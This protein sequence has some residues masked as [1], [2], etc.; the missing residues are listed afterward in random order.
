MDI[1]TKS[2]FEEFKSNFNITQKKEEDAFED[3]ANYCILS[4]H[5]KIETVTKDTIK[6]IHIGGGNDTGIDGFIFVV[7][8]KQV[9]TKQEVKDLVKANGYLDVKF[10][11]IQAKT[12]PKF[13]VSEIGTFLE[14]SKLV[15]RRL[16]ED[17]LE[18]PYNQDIGD[19]YEL[20]EF[21]YS[22]A[23]KFLNSRKPTLY[24]Y[25]VTTGSYDDANNDVNS[26]FENAKTEIQSYGLLESIQWF[27]VDANHL[28][29][30]YA[31]TKQHEEAVVKVDQLLSL[32]EIDK[33]EQGYLFLLPFSEYRKLLI[34]EQSDTIKTVFNDNVR[35]YQGDK[36][37]NREIGKTIED[38]AFSL[39]TAMNNGIT[40]IA[41]EVIVTGKRIT[42]KD[43]QIVNGC[44]TSHVLYHKRNV[45]GIDN[46]V[47][48][49]KLIASSDRD[50][51][52]SIILGANS[53][54][55]VT[56]EQ[57]IALSELQERIEAY[58]NAV[59]KTERLYY[60]RRSKQ[61]KGDNKI[62]DYKVVTIAA[63]IKAMVSMFLSEPHNVSGYYGCIVEKLQQGTKKIFSDDYKVD[64]YYT[65]GFANY[66][67]IHMFDFGVIPR[68][69]TKAKYQLL[70]AFRLV[71]DKEIGAMPDLNNKHMPDYCEKVNQILNDSNAC[72]EKFKAASELLIRALNRNYAVDKDCN[73][74]SVT[75]KLY[76]LAK[77]HAAPKLIDNLT[78]V[79]PKVVG[80]IDLD[81]LNTRTRP[82]KKARRKL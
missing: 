14:G 30:L 46:L 61:Y 43:Y 36:P 26:R 12:S 16:N 64:I 79:G 25:Y 22:N 8:G 50:V 20:V 10:V 82:T 19:C 18:P 70:L 59:K 44:Q 68:S 49:V 72:E 55:A 5:Q 75:K 67:M 29:R 1:I 51:R 56:R 45:P 71:C 57:L 38:K 17:I 21:I 69:L 74:E 53:Q 3:F 32:P 48:L 62:P 76:E 81:T 65:C 33:V 39:F 7:N 28:M 27:P 66:K 41:K 37:V 47:L 6:S 4:K 35:A 80:K 73:D 78:A 58:Y 40:I 15:F 13:D 52:N 24:L 34:D 42:M 63:Q 9:S 54:T 77:S 2:N 23:S 60:E 11:I 31:A